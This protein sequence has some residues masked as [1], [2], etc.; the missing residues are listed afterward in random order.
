MQLVIPL[1]KMY[2]KPPA[3][4]PRLF[5]RHP[6]KMHNVIDQLFSGLNEKGRL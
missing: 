1:R 2:R 3:G 5:D 6:Y 4:L